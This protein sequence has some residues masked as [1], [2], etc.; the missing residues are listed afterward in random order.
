VVTAEVK[1]ALATLPASKTQ[2]EVSVTVEK[3]SN[4][5]GEAAADV[6]LLFKDKRSQTLVAVVHGSAQVSGT[7]KPG[8]LVHVALRRAA[9]TAV[10]RSQPLFPRPAKKRPVGH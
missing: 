3:T 5:A 6:A 9:A 1:T 8:E 7:G 4:R 10:R 2:Y